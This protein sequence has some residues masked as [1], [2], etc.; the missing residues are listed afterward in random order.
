MRESVNQ[1]IREHTA[2]I[3]RATR[4]VA[5]RLGLSAGERE[6]LESE[7]WL[8]FVRNGERIRD[9]Y[10]GR[11]SVR[12]YLCTI[13]T[14]LARDYR[15]RK[16]GKW[17]PSV[18]ALRLG[19]AAVRLEVL[20]HRDGFSRSEAVKRV[21]SECS[22]RSVAE[23][24]DLVERLPARQLR[25]RE[26]ALKYEPPVDPEVERELD[27]TDRSLRLER[28]KKEIGRAVAGMTTA[29]RGLLR[30]RFLRGRTVSE[31]ARESQTD[32]RVLYR[33]LERSLRRIRQQL[34]GAGIDREQLLSVVQSTDLTITFS[35]LDA[36]V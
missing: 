12:T 16:W 30:E 36:S 29:E 24:E 5:R 6:E 32:R 22:R 9:Q 20:V 14:N 15:I 25:G 4:L 3:S 2:V 1:F 28:V 21:R 26:V 27:R 18:A 23:L 11:S 8:H 10:E 35:A 7:V 33:T 19:A 31:I 13:I 34:D 17:R